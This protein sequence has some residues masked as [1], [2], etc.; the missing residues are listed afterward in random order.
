M[1]LIAW[2]L[3]T[4][5]TPAA[6]VATGYAYHYR[7]QLMAQVA[8]NRGLV[9]DRQVDG[10]ASTPDCSHIGDRLYA[11]IAGEAV[12]LQQV[13]CSNSKDLPY[14]RRVLNLVVEVDWSLARRQ[15]WA[16]Y[17][18]APGAGKARAT[19]LGWGRR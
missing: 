17:A 19:V 5:I 4:L 14:Q 15:G 8:A 16:T 9:L 12:T 10:Y 7:P 2:L 3:S 1:N 18:G 6:P 11:V 13:D